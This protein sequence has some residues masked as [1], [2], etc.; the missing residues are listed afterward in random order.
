MLCAMGKPCS[1]FPNTLQAKESL[2]HVMTVLARTLHVA[3]VDEGKKKDYLLEMKM[4]KLVPP[5][6]IYISWPFFPISSDLAT[7]N[8]H[9][10]L[11]TGSSLYPSA[12]I[13]SD[14]R[15]I[16]YWTW[17]SHSSTTLNNTIDNLLCRSVSLDCVSATACSQYLT[18]TAQH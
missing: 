18:P 15:I 10:Q 2:H 8:P 6:M 11:P 16:A 9:S 13:A 7:V 12:T 17:L 3:W 4:R 14:L 5:F 1:F